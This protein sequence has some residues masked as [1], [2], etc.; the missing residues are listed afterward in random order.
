MV[1]VVDRLVNE[2]EV[3]KLFDVP[4]M[5]TLLVTPLLE[6]TTLEVVG[7]LD[8]EVAVSDEDVL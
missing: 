3:D 1:A 4:A 8:K 7:V 6:A 2:D 5:E